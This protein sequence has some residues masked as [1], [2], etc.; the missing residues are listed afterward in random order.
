MATTGDH[1]LDIRPKKPAAEKAGVRLLYSVLTALMILSAFGLW[2]VPGASWA[3]EVLLVKFAMSIFLFLGAGMFLSA[4]NPQN[5][6]SET[7][8]ETES[9]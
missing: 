8:D 4:S 9:Q 6:S 5:Q 2:F 7:Q 3:P 1:M